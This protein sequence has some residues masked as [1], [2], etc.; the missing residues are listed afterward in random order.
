MVILD[1]LAGHRKSIKEKTNV[2]LKITRR[3]PGILPF[4]NFISIP[5]HPN[6]VSYIIIIFDSY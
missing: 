4:N 1:N 5:L 6:S 3:K 2:Q